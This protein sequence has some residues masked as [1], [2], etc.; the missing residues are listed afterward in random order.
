MNRTKMK[1]EN[2]EVQLLGQILTQAGTEQTRRQ[3]DEKYDET[4]DL[5]C[6]GL[7]PAQTG[8]QQNRR[9]KQTRLRQS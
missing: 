6:F 9:Y 5:T 8:T 7:I 4:I 2:D 3:R 1:E